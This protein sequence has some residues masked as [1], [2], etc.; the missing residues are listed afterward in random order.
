MRFNSVRNEAVQRLADYCDPT[1]QRIVPS[2]IPEAMIEI[3]K[4]FDSAFKKGNYNPFDDDPDSY[5]PDTSEIRPRDLVFIVFDR[6]KDG[7]PGRSNDDY[8][9]IKA[10]CDR[11]H[12]EVL[13]S[14]PMFEMWL[15]F[16]HKDVDYDD[17]YTADLD[18]FIRVKLAND[19]DL[20]EGKNLTYPDW[21]YDP[22]VEKKGKRLDEY[23]FN[24]FY[25][26]SFADALIESM[27]R[28]TDFESL[29]DYPGSSV[30]I[31]LQR[32]IDESDNPHDRDV[33]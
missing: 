24:K 4:V 12:Y 27:K 5:N 14:S 28:D 1:G 23:R 25:K 21:I 22:D 26:N 2:R 16:H 33:Q 32:L 17:Y 6:D 29:L 11:L 10:R 13:L 15:L 20:K 18:N 9:K 3:I 30:G 8:R 7:S 31:I 19:I